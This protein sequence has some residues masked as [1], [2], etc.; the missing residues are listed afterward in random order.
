[1]S[2]A[3]ELLMRA[4][5]R[6]APLL[7][8]RTGR[9]NPRVRHLTPLGYAL[10]AYRLLSPN[11]R[12]GA[13]GDAPLFPAVVQVQT[14]NRCNAACPMCPYPYTVGR[15]PYRLMPDALWEKIASE[16]AAEPG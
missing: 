8:S 1:M 10:R 15:E 14:V 4:V 13:R 6:L 7:H 2:F 11:T 3:F 5:A 16:C 9:A 12:I